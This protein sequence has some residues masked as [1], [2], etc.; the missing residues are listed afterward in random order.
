MQTIRTEAFSQLALYPAN[1]G[2]DPMGQQSS[3]VLFVADS[4]GDGLV[5]GKHNKL[6]PAAL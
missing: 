2:A 4:L 1:E 6:M 3:P 5:W